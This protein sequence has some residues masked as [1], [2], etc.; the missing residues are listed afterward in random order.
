MSNPLCFVAAASAVFQ[1]AVIG[2]AS[3]FPKEYPQGVMAGM[4]G[5]WGGGAWWVYGGH[6]E[7]MEGMVG[8]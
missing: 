8:V 5:V 7:F 1:G 2:L 3:V 6:V 4:V